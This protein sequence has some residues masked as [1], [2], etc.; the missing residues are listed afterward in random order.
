MSDQR[1]E[2]RPPLG[3]IDLGDRPVV[4][5]I[6]AEPIDGLGRKGDEFARPDQAG[7]AGDLLIADG[8]LHAGSIAACRRPRQHGMTAACGSC[9]FLLQW[10]AIHVPARWYETHRIA[11]DVTLIRETHVA[12]WMRCNIWHIRGRERD[13]LI[14]S[15]MGLRPLKAEVARLAERPVAAI[16]TH[17]HFDHIGGAHEFDT[18]L[19]H[20]SEAAVHEHPGLDNTCARAWIGAD[21]L[22]ALPH[23][24]YALSEY[25]ITPAPLTGYLDEGDVL[26]TGNRV[27]QV[28]HLPG[29]S[30]GSIA[31]YEAATRTLF[32]GDVVYDGDLIDNAWHSDAAVYRA[33][34]ERL[35]TLPVDTVHAG[36]G[37]S[38]GQTRLHA[39]IDGYLA[40]GMRIA[41]LGAW[42]ARQTA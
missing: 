8:M 3:G 21:L 33:S 5:R 25:R 18:R 12:P 38:F 19:G 15:G 35:K 14:D 29:H 41:D 40:G 20:E 16:S 28:F 22:T 10:P 31:L 24:G 34:L 27:F 39:I 42:L 11:D 9:S 2:A 1:I 17:C 4:G 13:L 6:G 37:E 32:S 23:E 36:H 30:P 7:G 26:D